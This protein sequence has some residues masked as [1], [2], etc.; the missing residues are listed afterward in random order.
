[1][2]ELRWILASCLLAAATPVHALT[3]ITSTTLPATATWGPPE[4][5]YRIEP[6]TGTTFTI[7]AGLTLTI[8]PSTLVRLK[9]GVSLVVAG[10]LNAT[11][12]TFDVTPTFTQWGG[13]VAST[14]GVLTMSGCTIQNFGTYPADGT[15]QQVAA[16]FANNTFVPRA[17]GLFNAIRLRSSTIA[18]SLTL[19]AAPNPFCY[20]TFPSAAIEVRN[21]ANPVLT[22]GS[23]TVIKFSPNSHL[24]T[25]LSG[26]PGGLRATGVVFTSS[27]DDTLGNTDNQ[28]GTPGPQQWEGITLDPTTLDAQTELDGCTIRYGGNG[29][30][31]GIALA[32]CEPT[33]KNCLIDSNYLRGMSLSGT[34]T[35][36]NVFNNTFRRSV[37]CEIIATPQAMVNVVPNNT[38]DPSADGKFNAY[39]LASSATIS[40]SMTLPLPPPGFCYLGYTQGG[41]SIEVRG[42]GGPVLTIADGTLIKFTSG[43]FIRTGYSGVPGGLRAR[44]VV[45]TSSRDDTLSDTNGDGTATTPG[46]QQW[47]GLSL[48]PTTLD[49]QTELDGCTIRY[50]GNGPNVGIA[51]ADCEPTVKNCL[52]DS[53]YL[54]GMS[55]SGTATG[56]NVFNNTFRRNVQC[57]IIATPQAMVNVVPNNTIDP[58]AD[59]K[60]NAYELASSATIS[61]SMTLPHPAT[62]FCYLGYT[63]GG[64]SIEV[65]GAGG[66]VLTIADGTLIKFT[67]GSFIRTGYSGVPGGL[68]ARGVVFTSSR[69]DTLSDSNGDGA[70]T[71]PAAQ[72]WE[73]ITLDPTTLDAQTELDGCTIRYGG[74][75]P[76]AGI[77]I[78][79]CEPTVRNCLIDSNYLR[80]MILTGT[81]QGTQVTNNLIRS[82]TSYEIA[83]TLAPLVRLI[84][85]NTIAMSADLRFN[86]YEVLGGPANED[87]SIPS[88]PVGMCFVFAANVSISPGRTLSVAAG[89]VFKFAT[90]VSL[91]VS[92]TILTSGDVVAPYNP[93]V[94]TSV[95]DDAWWGDTNG[96][97][98]GTPSPGAWGRID[99]AG[100]NNASRIDGCV[101]A[102]GGAMSAGQLRISSTGAQADPNVRVEDSFFVVGLPTGGGIV[103]LSSNPRITACGFRG[104]FSNAG[105]QNLTAGQSIDATGNWWGH[106]SG[107]RDASASAANEGILACVPDQNIGDGVAVTDCVLYRPWLTAP[108]DAPVVDVPVAPPVVSGTRLV[109][110]GPTPAQHAVDFVL[111]VAPGETG[112]LDIFDAAGRS[113]RRFDLA[114][115]IGSQ[116]MIRWSL[117]ADDGVRVAPGIYLARLTRNQG[118]EAAR[119]VVLH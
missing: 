17:D 119:I 18:A 43:S 5:E 107:P 33:V 88:A 23:N 10:T 83:A 90:G 118:S 34:A 2:R 28:P 63:Q 8:Q 42:A 13:V 109:R 38:V 41:S 45:F 60:F 53:N 80:G 52:I 66:P 44:G 100:P 89:N 113:I 96:N 76:N 103:V 105:V 106:T 40:A 67:S 35:G 97:G 85:Q 50:G 47:E 114:G 71:T 26:L 36:I 39:E 99:I 78:F 79:D 69:D 15:V 11:G 3:I 22:I 94:F 86:G 112:R 61:Q 98:A 115:S 65:R 74:N 117:E 25:G 92:G 56:I 12:A 87:V 84:G 1:M 95:N 70:A 32:D 82:N 57:E 14:G 48:D 93:I 31:V 51:L 58:S 55:L 7:P 19:S 37:Q 75:G 77:G 116:R 16:L 72:Q 54:R 9:G 46:P 81:T 73:G 91:A 101:F 59:D 62:G 49:V 4:T 68:R 27:L 102:Y 24:R 64:S 20:I 110:F 104:P 6:T 111:D 30:N 21:A 108:L 29:P